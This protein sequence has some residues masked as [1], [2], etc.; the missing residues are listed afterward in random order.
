M[1]SEF[2]RRGSSTQRYPEIPRLSE[3]YC[4][5]LGMMASEGCCW[6]NQCLNSLCFAEWEMSRL[7]RVPSMKKVTRTLTQ[8]HSH[9]SVQQGRHLRLVL[10]THHEE[11]RGE[12]SSLLPPPPPQFS[13]SL[14]PLA[15]D[16]IGAMLLSHV[17]WPGHHPCFSLMTSVSCMLNPRAGTVP[18]CSRHSKGTV[19]TLEFPKEKFGKL[20]GTMGTNKKQSP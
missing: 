8:G 15:N 11:R 10:E 3:L 5:H 20:R 18:L 4:I 9:G 14:S 16:Q 7:L 19:A 1:P 6:G 13:A 17:P 2:L 12:A